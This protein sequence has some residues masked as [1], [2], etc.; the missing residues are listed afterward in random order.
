MPSVI[1]LVS[2]MS[3]RSR[4]LLIELAGTSSDIG[5][6]PGAASPPLRRRS[7]QRILLRM[8]FVLAPCGSDLNVGCDDAGR[9]VQTPHMVVMGG[10]ARRG[11]PSVEA[12]DAGGVDSDVNAA[13][14]RRGLSREVRCR[15]SPSVDAEP[16]Q[17]VEAGDSSFEDMGCDESP[18][19]DTDDS[20]F[21]DDLRSS[22]K[23]LRLR[24]EAQRP[25]VRATDAR[26]RLNHEL[27]CASP[28]V[29]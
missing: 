19:G 1:S 8:P 26:L 22:R 2:V 27:S 28:P 4:I 5:P 24:R 18:L 20:V 7:E 10:E 9:G 21:A 13:R 6:S 23:E 14:E 17:L 11:D 16:S 25:I 12:A 29:E 15:S 3:S